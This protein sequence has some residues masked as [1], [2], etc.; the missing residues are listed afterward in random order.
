M[1]PTKM[2]LKRSD[3]NLLKTH[4]VIDYVVNLHVHVHM[5]ESYLTNST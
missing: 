4:D 3:G 5:S 1:L 2:K